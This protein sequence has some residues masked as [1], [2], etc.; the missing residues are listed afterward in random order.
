VSN[1]SAQQQAPG[2]F[3]ALVVGAG[4]TGI[5]VATELVSKMRAAIDNGQGPSGSIEPP[6]VILADRKS[7]I[8]SD[9]GES[10]R[11]VIERALASLGIETRTATD[12][13]CIEQHCATA[14]ERRFLQQ[15]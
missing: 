11:P 15:P 7:W 12:V 10:A 2:Q 13:T 5:E 14:T 9:I 4:L 3:T 8:G 1:M 6:R